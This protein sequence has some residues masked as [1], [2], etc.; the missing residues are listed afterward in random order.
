[1][2]DQ[3]LGS[4]LATDRDVDITMGERGTC[5]T[6]QLFHD[7]LPDFTRPAQSF[8]LENQELGSSLA[9]DKNVCVTVGER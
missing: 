7:V 1:M 5:S 3:E 6:R 9:T 2:K 8:N 4:T